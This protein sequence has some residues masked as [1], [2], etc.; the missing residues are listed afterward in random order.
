MRRE[1]PR[2]ALELLVNKVVD[3]VPYLASIRDLSLG[4]VYLNEVSE[5]RHRPDAR[6]ALE[7]MLPGQN[8]VMWLETDVV[9]HEDGRGT[10]LMFKELT[11]RTQSRLESF[12]GLSLSNPEP[13]TA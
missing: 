12:L 5:P 1:N 9:R 2:V 8:E 10:G 7:L 6:V 3:G 11:P 13:C 4:G